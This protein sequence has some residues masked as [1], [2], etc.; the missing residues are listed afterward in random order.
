MIDSLEVGNFK[1]RPKIKFIHN[2]CFRACKYFEKANTA[3]DPHTQYFRE[4][5]D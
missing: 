5:M 4:W 3:I 2:C 1:N